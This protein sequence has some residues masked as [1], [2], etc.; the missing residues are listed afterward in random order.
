M[1][2]LNGDIAVSAYQMLAFGR[3]SDALSMAST[4]IPGSEPSRILSYES[5]S[6]GTSMVV[7]DGLRLADTT[8]V[9]ITIIAREIAPSN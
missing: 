7:P 3:S 9:A 1:L 6:S 8:F 4:V 5:R 2:A